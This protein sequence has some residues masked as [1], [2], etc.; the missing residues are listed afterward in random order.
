MKTSL[1]ATLSGISVALV[2]MMSSKSFAAFKVDC[3][4]PQNDVL[5]LIVAYPKSYQVDFNADG[6]VY[7]ITFAK[8]GDMTRSKMTVNYVSKE[9]FTYK[10]ENV[11]VTQDFN[12]IEL[13][14]V[15]LGTVVVASS[16]CQ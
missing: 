9:V 8:N 1:K 6:S 7:L 10:A 4:H 2:L 3:G 5:G 15:G 12:G 14:V 16:V 13:N 11:I